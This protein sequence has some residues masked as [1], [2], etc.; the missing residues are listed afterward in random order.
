MNVA[1]YI[2]SN[3][4]MPYILENSK[5]YSEGVKYLHRDLNTSIV[6]LQMEVKQSKF[7]IGLPLAFKNGIDVT[8]LPNTDISINIATISKKHCGAS[9]LTTFV[10]EIKVDAKESTIF[11]MDI[12]PRKDSKLALNS[13]IIKD[14]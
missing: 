13:Q 10:L 6:N 14:L 9:H 12:L 11:T 1:N 4:I 2:G 5:Q 3:G 7:Y 8:T